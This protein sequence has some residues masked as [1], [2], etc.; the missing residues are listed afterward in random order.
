MEVDNPIDFKKDDFIYKIFDENKDSINRKI[1]KIISIQN[2]YFGSTP[3]KYLSRDIALII[4][5]DEYY[6]KESAEVLVI[7]TILDGKTHVYAKHLQN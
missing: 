3:E 4:P 6:I 2:E 5:K 1:Y 7:Q